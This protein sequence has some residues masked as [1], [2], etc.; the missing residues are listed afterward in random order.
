[1]EGILNSRELRKRRDEQSELAQQLNQI[2]EQNL[3]QR[4]A[5]SE[6]N[7][8]AA[9]QRS[10]D[11]LKAAEDRIASNEKQ[12]DAKLDASQSLSDSKLSQQ[13]DQFAHK[14]SLSNQRADAAEA[15]MK[16]MEQDFQQKQAQQAREFLN[17]TRTD[18]LEHVM[19]RADKSA[20][21]YDKLLADPNAK[22]SPSFNLWTRKSQYHHTLADK[23]AAE[24]GGQ[25]GG[26]DTSTSASPLG[27]G[28][29]AAHLATPLTAQPPAPASP[30]GL[31]PQNPTAAPVALPAPQP[32]AQPAA[33]GQPPGVRI[34]NKQTG[35]TFTY[36]G[37]PA[38]VPTNQFDLIQ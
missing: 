29:T 27:G 35:Q 12:N 17:K 14:F 13:N 1:M 2:R 37:N 8:D 20:E 10:A 16:Q 28:P 36:G 33:Q 30:L 25:Q 32:T 3:M 24:L 11:T 18:A 6:M 38:D 5:I 21:Y 15:K 26:G 9:S 23:V 7:R 4:L 22:E 31:P 34:K 19:N